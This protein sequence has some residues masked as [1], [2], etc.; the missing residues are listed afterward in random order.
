[1]S[2]NKNLN[3]KTNSI[4]GPR[5]GCALAAFHTVV[6]IPGAVPITHCGPGCVD[7][8][9]SSFASGN[10]CQGGG[11]AEI[12]SVNAGENEVVFGGENKLR[13]LIK[14]TLKVI[15]GELFV[16]FSGCIG[17]LVGDD[18]ASVVGE[19]QKKGIPIV[20]AETGG[21]KGNNLI[22][23]EIVIKS[24]IDQYVGDY[25]GEKEKGTVNVWSEIPYFNTYWRGDLVE[26]KR[27]LEGIGLKVNIL[28][29]YESEGVS[30]WRNIPKAEFNLVISPWVGLNTAK[31]L[32]EKYGQP[33]LHI[34]VLPI[35][36]DATSKVL[37]QIVEFTGVD[38]EKA[39]EFI[40]KEEKWYYHYL[41]NFSEFYSESFYG[42]PAKYVVVGD[43]LYNLA[44]NNFLVNQMGLIPA[45][46]FITDNP[47]EKY[48]DKIIEEYNKLQDDYPSD[49]EFIEDG[50]TVIEKI[51]EIEF[52]GQFPV[53]LG[54]SWEKDVS[55]QINGFLIETSFPVTNEVV[56]IRSY[57][58]Y[59]GAL[60][61]IE[62]IYSTAVSLVP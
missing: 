11:G 2:E 12:P 51:K 40:E 16:V 62:K 36:A 48:R 60:E 37:R 17:E 47:L 42:L 29:G 46:Q 26:I 24:I 3:I 28:F 54:T 50:Y 23:H 57:V 59:R 38:K 43:S 4:S 41:E 19:F 10:G 32:E 34:P 53:I 14:G 21:F 7:K 33:F 30:E 6:A 8:Q 27:V 56:I 58:G 52:G 61:L 49:V 39:E 13:N 5:Y 44:L 1:M 20:Y 15:K 22:G 9:H 55:R 25:H 18:V 35:G 31:H 45:K